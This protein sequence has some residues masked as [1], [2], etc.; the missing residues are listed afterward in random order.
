MTFEQLMPVMLSTPKSHTPPSLPL[1]FVGG[2]GL[3]TKDIGVIMSFQGVYSMLAQI[4]LFPMAVRCFGSLTVFRAVAIAFPL[5]YIL[6]PYLVLLPDRWRM[7]GLAMCLIMK[8]TGHV[9]AFPSNAI[10]LTNSAPSTLVLGT[11]NGVAASTAS[12]SRALGPTLSGLIHSAGLRW[13]YSGLAW[14]SSALVC[15]VGAL[16]SLWMEEVNARLGQHV[17]LDEEEGQ[18][19]AEEVSNED[20]GGNGRINCDGLAASGTSTHV[21]RSAAGACHS[22]SAGNA[23]VLPATTC[24]P[25]DSRRGR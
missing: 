16:E 13:G 21:A 6:V 15:V 2:F 19:D 8:I 3:H 10:L 11:I 25:A 1:K 12:L 7:F 5:L 20:S 9:L 24:S 22:L 17:P 23:A 4:F 18:G 14:W